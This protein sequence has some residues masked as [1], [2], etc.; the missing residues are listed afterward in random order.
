MNVYLVLVSFAGLFT[1]ETGTYAHKP[2]NREEVRIRGKVFCLDKAGQPLG[3]CTGHSGLFGLWTGDGRLYVFLS[4]DPKAAMFRDPC[5]REKE[6]EVTGWLRE[7]RLEINKLRALR[8]GQLVEM[9]FRC[10]VCNITAFSPGPCWCCRQEFELREK[11][12]RTP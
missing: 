2:E 6:I 10:D 7:K 11:P 3:D 12:T 8:D 4:E 5:V 9:F 1:A